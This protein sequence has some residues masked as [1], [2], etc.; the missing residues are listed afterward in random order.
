[1]VRKLNNK[2]KVLSSIVLPYYFGIAFLLFSVAFLSSSHPIVY[3]IIGIA[4]GAIPQI[5]SIIFFDTD[6]L[7]KIETKYHIGA[8]ILL[9]IFVLPSLLKIYLI[10][11]YHWFHHFM[12]KQKINTDY[13]YYG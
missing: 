13:N 5:L 4:I 12:Q 1:M 10:R 8:Y 3:A 9:T 6:D 7:K 2:I 11:I